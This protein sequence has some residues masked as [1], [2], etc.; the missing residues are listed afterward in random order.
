[1]AKEFEVNCPTGLRGRM[2]GMIVRDEGLLTDPKVMREGL[3]VSR[4][5][6]ACWLETLDPGPYVGANGQPDWDR[7]LRADRFYAFLMLRVESRGAIYEFRTTC[8]SQGCQRPIDM[9]LDLSELPVRKFEP[10]QLGRIRTDTPF[11]ATTLSGVRVQFRMLTGA[12][13]R[14]I[15]TLPSSHNQTALMLA[16]RIVE[17]DGVGRHPGAIGKWV[18]ELDGLE[19]DDLRDR[20]DAEEAGVDT[21]FD[22]SC[23]TCGNVMRRL[24]LPI[25]ASFFFV[26]KRLTRSPSASFGSKSDLP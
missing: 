26:R 14:R 16:M 11:Q 4:M 20:I 18:E 3:I 23:D 25:E 24:F 1:M 8:D 7:V 19:A 5:L 17:V 15:A 10:D 12:D 22:I 13:E 6:Q 9:A 21:T 2:R